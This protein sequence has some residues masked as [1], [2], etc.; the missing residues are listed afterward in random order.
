MKNWAMTEE[1]LDRLL[2]WLDADREAAARKY[3]ALR[4]SLIKYFAKRGCA[5]A[6]D[7]ADEVIDRVTQR[8]D[9][10]TALLSDKPLPYIYGIA[11]HVHLQ[12]VSQQ[13]RMDSEADPHKLPERQ[14]PEEASEKERIVECLRQCL[15]RLKSDDR[16]TLILYYLKETQA[17]D[18][19][20]QCLAARLGCTINA[21]RLKIMRLRDQL[22]LCI[23]ACQQRG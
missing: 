15:Q 19:H 12:Y 3:E 9:R 10:Q 7:L 18:E 16:R 1:A 4:R 21:L 8:L 23:A 5:L 11:R 14:R 20:R 22:S 13:S 6:E 2:D 17:K